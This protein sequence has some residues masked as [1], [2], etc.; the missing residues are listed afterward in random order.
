MKKHSRSIT[1]QIT[2]IIT[3]LVAGTVFLCWLLNTTIAGWYYTRNK[4]QTMHKAFESIDTASK[5]GTLQNSSYDV[6]FE[7]ICANG[8]MT[9]MVLEPDFTVVRC[10]SNAID[11][12]QV[13]FQEVVFGIQKNKAEI[14]EHNSRYTLEKET[15]SRMNAEYLV[16][17]GTLDDGNLVLMRTA[18]ESISETVRISNQLLAFIGIFAVIASI[19][20]V[21][22]V[23]RKITNPIV[24]LTGISQKMAELDF[25]AK[26][27]VTGDNEI[28]QLG[29][30]MN[31][32]SETLEHT[33]SELK[34]ANNELMIDIEKKEQIDEMR[35]D[36]LSNVS[37][38]L[39]TPL[40]LIQGYAEG[41]EECVQ[42]D[43]ESRNF[44]CSVIID[45]ADKMNQMV[46]KLLTLNQLEFG[47]DVVTMERF[48]LTELI[49]GV[50]GSSAILLEQN[51][52]HV[53]FEEQEPVYAWADEFKVEEVISNYLSNAIHHCEGKKEIR[54]TCKKSADSV[55]VS[56][57]NTGK[58]I[59]EE[60]L[61]NVWIKFYKVD[62]AR[63]REYGGSGI[64]LSIVKAIMDSFHRECGVENHADGVEFWFEL[65]ATNN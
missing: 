33:I 32:L 60:D 27:Q 25:D 59:P 45:E 19:I 44:Y 62:K 9:I 50:V 58:P 5:D 2:M 28:E 43:P 1:K 47:N 65:D 21:Y 40:A 24:Q 3:G 56:V 53:T 42:D 30:H 61:A 55:R 26:Y 31:Q 63:T 10:S 39:K 7:R 51:K 22:F 64:G 11:N 4:Q 13:Q 36:F 38:E 52:I 41:L 14:I 12:L 17:W 23:T 8:N 20:V 29:M 46:K 18:L 57:F 6:E 49:R 34:S 48:D 16:L 54:I 35:K 15:D 37:H